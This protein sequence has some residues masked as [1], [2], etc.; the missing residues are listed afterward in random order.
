MAVNEFIIKGNQNTTRLLNEL[1][2]SAQQYPCLSKEQEELLID[3]YHDDRDTL[4]RLLFMHNI[5]AVFNQAKQYMS[6]VDDFDSL[7][8][9]GMMGLAEA[10]KRFDIDKG[11]KFITYAMPWIRKYILANFYKKNIE[12]EKM[13][14]SLDSPIMQHKQSDGN[15]V[16]FENYVN[17]YFDPSCMQSK[18]LM[19]ELS[20]SEQYKICQDLYNKMEHDNTLSSIDKA[21][22]VDAFYNKEKTRDIAEKYSIGMSDVNQIK[23]KILDKFRSILKNEYKINSFQDVY[24]A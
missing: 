20:S 18:S 19:E 24:F 1:K 10:C 11:V 2:Q 16:S 3:K 12:I 4:N 5:K 21:V 17:D 15:D 9:D 14:T 22:F 13:S 8:Q 7:V 23:H 6:K